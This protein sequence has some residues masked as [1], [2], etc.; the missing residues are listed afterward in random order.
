MV[1]KAENSAIEDIKTLLKRQNID[2]D[3]LR[4]DAQV[5]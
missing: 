1:I 5:G 3:T 2:T 4:I